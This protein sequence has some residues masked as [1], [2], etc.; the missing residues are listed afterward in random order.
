M[1]EDKSHRG[2]SSQFFVAGELCRRGLV[3]VLTLGN[4][5][6]TDVLVSNKAGTRFAHVQVKTYRPGRDKTV[7]VGTK[8]ERDYGPAF[9]W[10]LAGIPEIESLAGWEYY[11]VPSS[12]FSKIVL[13]NHQLWMDTPGMKGQAHNESKVRAVAVPPAKTP[14][15]VHSIESYLDRWDL[16]ID[17]CTDTSLTVTELKAR[18]RLLEEG[19]V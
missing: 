18:E 5:P 16:I 11:V 2:A 4:C 19:D 10:V 15:T 12:E 9:F 6:N 14:Y 1:A 13:A 17:A 8:A 3:A 7:S